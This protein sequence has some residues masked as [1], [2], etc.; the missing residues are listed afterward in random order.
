MFILKG[1]LTFFAFL[2]APGTTGGAFGMLFGLKCNGRLGPGL[3]HWS[4][5]TTTA[6]V[7]LPVSG[8]L[9]G[10]ALSA[11]GLIAR[12]RQLA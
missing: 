5:Y 4:V 1:G 9:L 12:R 10:F 7:P 11:G 3:S 8:T 2:M 6:S